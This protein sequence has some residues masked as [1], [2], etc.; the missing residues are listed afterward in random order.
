MA[1]RRI[2]PFWGF[3]PKAP[4]ALAALQSSV[5]VQEMRHTKERDPKIKLHRAIN[6]IVYNNITKRLRQL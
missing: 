1:V 2:R 3:Y 5:L 6:P 4:Q